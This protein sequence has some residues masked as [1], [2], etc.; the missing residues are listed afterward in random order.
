[1]AMISN[2]LAFQH[3]A[4]AAGLTEPLLRT[5]IA[6]FYESVRRD[7]VLGPIFDEAIGDSWN[8]HIEKICS[9]WLT[10]TR[11]GAGYKGGDFIP[12]HMSLLTI[13]PELLPRWLS[14]FRATAREECSPQAADTLIDIAER[15]ADMIKHALA[16][17][18][19]GD[20][21]ARI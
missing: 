10:A 19:K 16:R 18:D 17:R 21:Q 7:G 8:A 6:K 9:F 1:M 15:M 14:L 4:A 20:A 11:L 3:R 12:A 2:R 13:T 5:I